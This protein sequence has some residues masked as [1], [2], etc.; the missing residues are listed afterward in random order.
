VVLTPVLVPT[1]SGARA[2]DSVRRWA[3]ERTG[4]SSAAAFRK[5]IEARQFSFPDDGAS[6]MNWTDG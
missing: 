2:D 4:M 1:N 5:E 6:M 3:S